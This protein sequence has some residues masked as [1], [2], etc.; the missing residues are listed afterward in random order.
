MQ[1]RLYASCDRAAPMV[2]S[3]EEGIHSAWRNN[4]SRG[5]AMHESKHIADVPSRRIEC[6]T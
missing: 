3:R 4:S 1:R 6:A 2:N 5:I